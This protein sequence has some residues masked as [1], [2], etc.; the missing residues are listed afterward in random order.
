MSLEATIKCDGNGCWREISI[1]DPHRLDL[2]MELKGEE[3][4]DDWHQDPDSSDYHYC[5]VCWK[6]VKEE[7][8]GESDD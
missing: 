6:K 8:E 4:E 7:L 1:E 5:P 2:H 3:K